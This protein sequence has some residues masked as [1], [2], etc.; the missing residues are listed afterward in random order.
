MHGSPLPPAGRTRHRAS[1]GVFCYLSYPVCCVPA[2]ARVLRVRNSRR[3]VCSAFGGASS[4]EVRRQK[5]VRQGGRKIDRGMESG[6]RR[7]LVHLEKSRR[8]ATGLLPRSSDECFRFSLFRLGGFARTAGPE[9]TISTF[10]STS[11][12]GGP[13]SFFAGLG[14]LDGCEGYG[15]A[16]KYGWFRAYHEQGARTEGCGLSTGA[17]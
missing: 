7:A 12:S 8:R 5:N 9:P 3:R 17:R 14:S 15:S 1:S 2:C 13:F 6:D 11:S 10:P 4:P 16:K